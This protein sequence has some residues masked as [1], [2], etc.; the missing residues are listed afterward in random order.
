MWL[1]ADRQEGQSMTASPVAMQDPSG[2]LASAPSSSPSARS[3]LCDEIARVALEQYRRWRSGGGSALVETSPAASPILRE[4]YRVGVG[5]AVTDA[6]MQSRSFQASHPWSAVL[7]SYIMRTAGAG[8]AFRYSTSH[9]TY[10]RA[11]RW[12]RLSGN[13][14]NPF[15]AFRATE[16]APRVGDV[17]CRSRKNSGATYDNIGDPQPRATHCDVVTDVRP[18]WIRVVG[19][20]LGRTV[21]ERWLRAL[22][23]GRLSL[24]GDQ[25]RTFAAI[26]CRSGPGS[27]PAPNPA[28][29]P[30]PAGLNDRVARVMELLVRSY[31]YPVNGAAGMVGNLIAESAVLPNRIEGSD[32]A[33]PMRA[34]DFTGRVRDFTPDQVRDR[35]FRGRTGP[36]LPG[37]G[38]AQWTSPNRRSGLF[39][40]VFWGRQLGSAVLWDLDAQVHYLVTELRGAYR[41]VNATLMSP[42]VTVDQAADAVL[43]RFERPAS[44]VGRPLADPAIQ[45][46]VGRRRAHAAKALQI[47]RATHPN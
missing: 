47:H 32:E 40:H 4:Y 33:T 36:R 28:S 42:G 45:T 9:Q 12:N 41:S 21:G 8:S 13:T 6:Q 19:G 26:C 34:P 39:R 11:A 25:S 7:V 15:W 44:V 18:S 37:I 46:V 43:L 20:N 35:S 31:G 30:P 23:N 5:I 10:I 3:P 1:T 38:I 27:S 24:G 14:A 22:P 17:V 29:G 16:V 2:H